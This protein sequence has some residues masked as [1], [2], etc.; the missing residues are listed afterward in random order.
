MVNKFLVP[1]KLKEVKGS[2]TAPESVRL[3]MVFVPCSLTGEFSSD[4]YD[5]ITQRWSKVKNDY[6]SRFVN[7]E[8]FKAGE[9]ITTAVASDVWVVQALCLTDKGKLD[10]TALDNCVKKVI[11]TAKYETAFVHVSQLTLTTFPALKKVLETGLLPEGLNLY[12]YSD[13]ASELVKR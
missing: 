12:C 2:I 1:G 7:R 3:A 11:S 8:N 5:K 6:R 9:I 10:K 4:V 13:T